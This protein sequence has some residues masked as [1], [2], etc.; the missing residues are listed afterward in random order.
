MADWGFLANSVT[1][2]PR[3]A[4]VSLDS[5]SAVS[6]VN[7]AFQMSGC[8]CMIQGLLCSSP[9]ASLACCSW[10]VCL[11]KPGP[12]PNGEIPS[13][14]S[15]MA[16]HQGCSTRP[17]PGKFA[18][19]SESPD[20]CQVESPAVVRDLARLWSKPS[21]TCQWAPGPLSVGPGNSTAQIP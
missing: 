2:W 10:T 4:S 21:G 15:T 5:P 3:K 19:S 12:S 13:D 9:I 20:F 6:E 7:L 14:L 16:V 11:E 18:R 1:D 17:G 8:Q